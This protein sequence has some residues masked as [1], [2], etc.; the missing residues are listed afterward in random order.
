MTGKSEERLLNCSIVSASPVLFHRAALD[1]QERV[2]L[3]EVEIES[4]RQTN[5]YQTEIQAKAL[6]TLPRGPKFR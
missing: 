1:T 6:G 4:Y 3:L 2:A 5:P